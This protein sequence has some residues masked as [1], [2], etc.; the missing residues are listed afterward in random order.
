MERPKRVGP[1]EAQVTRMNA[2]IER[3]LRRLHALGERLTTCRDTDAE[4]LRREISAAHEILDS[5]ADE[6]GGDTNE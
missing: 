2:D 3:A 6:L 4:S 1:E 5:V